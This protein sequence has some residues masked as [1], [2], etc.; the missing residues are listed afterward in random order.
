VVV[1]KRL[2]VHGGA[3]AHDGL[4]TAE[5]EKARRNEPSFLLRSYAV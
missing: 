2:N 1:D 5:Y 3:A 4:L